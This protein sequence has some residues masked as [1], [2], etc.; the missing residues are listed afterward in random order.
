MGNGHLGTFD[1]NT[2]SNYCYH[3][4]CSGIYYFP[5][6]SLKMLMATKMQFHF[7][8]VKEIYELLCGF[9][10]IIECS[11]VQVVWQ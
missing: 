5:A 2:A 7:P 1:F 8:S 6:I 9:L 3:K 10:Y 4:S 11:T